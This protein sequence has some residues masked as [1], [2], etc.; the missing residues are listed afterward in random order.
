MG[1]ATVLLSPT[2]VQ[3]QNRFLAV[4]PRIETHARIYFR[5]LKC[6]HQRDEALAESFA[7]A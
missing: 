6:P 1:A 4:L 5:H 7:L 3:L 2:V